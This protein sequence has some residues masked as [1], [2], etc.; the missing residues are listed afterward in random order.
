ME[1]T[2]SERI[3]A[4]R[5]RVWSAL[6]D[7]DILRQCIPGCKSLDVTGENRMAAQ[8]RLKI[9]VVS[10]TFNGEVTLEDINAPE[11]YRIV[12]EGKGGVAGFAAGSASVALAEAD[13]ATVLTYACHAQIGGK[14]A[15]M[16]SR[17]IDATARKLATQFFSTFNQL[18]SEET[19]DAAEPDSVPADQ[20]A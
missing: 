5:S 18:V 20:T 19:S 15:R 16:G 14:I 12:G 7:P 3:E 4:S 8:V 10:A 13:G 11:S 6:N 2:G 17:L 9:G 1:M